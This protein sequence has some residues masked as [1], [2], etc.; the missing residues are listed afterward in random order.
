[1]GKLVTGNKIK[2]QFGMGA[3]STVMEYFTHLE[4][5]YLFFFVPKFSYSVRTQQINPRKVYAI[6]TGLI[7]VNTGEFSDYFD[8]ELENMVYLHLRRSFDEICYFSDTGECDFIVFGKNKVQKIIQV[9]SQLHHDN[10]DNELNGLFAAL[11]FFDVSEGDL[12]TW[13]QK[14]HFEKD[15]KTANVISYYE[16][17]KQNLLTL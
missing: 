14:D 10:L 3:T 7:K 13:N 6:D 4:Y 12:I 5:S 8:R 1:V 11:E 17:V 15:G 9:S 16:Y 2:S